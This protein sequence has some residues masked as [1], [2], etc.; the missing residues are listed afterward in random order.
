MIPGSLDGIDP[1][2]CFL[3]R[4]K[5]SGS[6]LLYL[7]SMLTTKE[8]PL[9]VGFDKDGQPIPLNKVKKYSRD[10]LEFFKILAAG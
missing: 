9:L 8:K 7:R 4:P 2:I 1:H 10:F 6:E 5:A 3:K